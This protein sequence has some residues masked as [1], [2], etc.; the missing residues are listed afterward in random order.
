MR[1]F[2]FRLERLLRYRRS[3]TA[4][5]RARLAHRVGMLTRAET[6]SAELRGIRNA[7]LVARLRALETGLTAREASNLHEHL[8]RIG[9]AIDTADSDVE[10]ARKEVDKARENLVE[11]RRDERVIELYRKRQWQAWLK[12][13]YRDESKILDDSGTIRHVRRLQSEH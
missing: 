7:S 3:L 2:R 9:E 5:E 8:V 4:R 6:H 10:S 12:D 13:Y 1:R 11:R